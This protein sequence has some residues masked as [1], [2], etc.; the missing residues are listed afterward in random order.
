MIVWLISARSTLVAGISMGLLVGLFNTVLTGIKVH[1]FSESVIQGRGRSGLGMA[2]RF[3]TAILGALV[4]LRFPEYVSVGGLLIGLGLTQVF[5]LGD[6]IYS[7]IN[8][9][10]N[11]QMQSGERGE[12]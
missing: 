4:A 12:S 11:N 1:K 3:A 10:Q 7:Q 2:T 5:A 8:Q 6:A 9:K